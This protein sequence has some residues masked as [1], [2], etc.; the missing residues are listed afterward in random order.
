M[1][2][3]HI[4]VL[5]GESIDALNIKSDGVY[6]DGTLGG[7]GHSSEIAK[8]LGENGRLVM[9]DLDETAINF[10]KKRLEPFN[11]QKT[12]VHN[13]FKNFLSVMDDEKIG[14]FD[15]IILDLGVSSYQI[16]TASRGFSYMQDGELNMA[17]DE[18]ARL[19]AEIVVNE[20][21]ESALERIFRDYG[22]EKFAG[23]IAKA[24]TTIRKTKKITTTKELAEIITNAI[25]ARARFG[26]GHPAKRVFQAI[27]IEVNGEL[28]GLK[29]GL[30]SMVR[31]GLNTGGRLAVITF[32]SLEDRIV[33]EAFNLLASDC[34]CDKK[35]PVC[36]CH[37]KAEVRL[38]SKKPILP[39]PDELKNNPR[40]HSAKLRVLEKI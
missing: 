39:S 35:L 17:M 27:R 18:H 7:G 21:T 2:F 29:E 10:A 14:G 31:N 20:Y 1:E 23:R 28:E 12:F 40:S 22:E 11:C 34:I 5:L 25:P 4:S 32:H 37:H 3:C 19:N 33:K 38:V 26:A 6:M 13:N 30:L 9:F 16:D 24:I 36:V 15:G 8:R